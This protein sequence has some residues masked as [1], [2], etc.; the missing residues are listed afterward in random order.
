MGFSS[1]EVAEGVAILTGIRFASEVGFREIIVESDSSIVISAIGLDSPPLV[2]LG[3]IILNI[4][5]YFSLFD[6]IFFHHVS[7][8]CNKIAHHLAKVSLLLFSIS[9]WL[10]EP[11]SCI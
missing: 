3:L 11:S 8:S 5:N 10:E 4:L 6:V 2:P 9:V 1:V 7:R